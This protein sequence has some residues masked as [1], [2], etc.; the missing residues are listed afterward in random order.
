M[1]RDV[2]TTLPGDRAF[3]MLIEDLRD[4]THALAESNRQVSAAMIDLRAAVDELQRRLAA[5]ETRPRPCPDLVALAQT[6]AK[7]REEAR[8]RAERMEDRRW[9]LWVRLLAQGV[10]W[11]ASVVAGA[12]GALWAAGKG[13]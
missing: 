13:W 2:T 11:A 6:W 12:V 3:W 1:T 4:Q 5:M 7:S 10:V 8:R 9:A